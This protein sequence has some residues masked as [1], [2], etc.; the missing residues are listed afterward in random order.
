MTLFN[1]G[2]A[3]K[4]VPECLRLGNTFFTHMS[5]FGTV[6]KADG[7]MPIHFDEQDL[8]S[9]VFHLEKPKKGHLPRLFQTENG[10]HDRSLQGALEQILR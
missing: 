4:I 3:Q 7:E 10:R 6:D 2:L 5:V 8:I 1:I 9:C